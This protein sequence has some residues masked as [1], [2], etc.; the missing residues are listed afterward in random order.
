M[1][2]R[3]EY[4]VIR[5]PKN[6]KVKFEND[7]SSWSEGVNLVGFMYV[8]DLYGSHTYNQVGLIFVALFGFVVSVSWELV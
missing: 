5:H 3:L 8:H 1:S 2:Q 6:F 4:D 7:W